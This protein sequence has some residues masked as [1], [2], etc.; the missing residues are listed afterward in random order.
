[1]TARLTEAELTLL[2]RI[3]TAT[4]PEVLALVA[5]VRALRQRVVQ[6]EVGRDRL[7]IAV[8]EMDRERIG[9]IERLQEDLRKKR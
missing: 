7:A 6:L 1:M 9:T 5:E 2:E 3:D 8:A 4:T